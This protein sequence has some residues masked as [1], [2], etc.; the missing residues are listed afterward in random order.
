MCIMIDNNKIKW[1]I[2]GLFSSYHRELIHSARKRL[3]SHEDAEDIVNEVWY[4]ATIKAELLYEHPNK[5]AWLYSVLDLCI[6]KFFSKHK[7][8]VQTMPL[9]EALLNKLAI[10]EDYCLENDGLEKYKNLLTELEWEYVY[11]RFYEGMDN[12]EIAEKVSKSYSSITSI[13]NRVKK[14][15]KFFFMT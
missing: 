7:R 1:F 14:K 6:K 4:I 5:I 11:Y 9:D 2:E 10:E 13:G 3:P 15:I 8:E 12:D